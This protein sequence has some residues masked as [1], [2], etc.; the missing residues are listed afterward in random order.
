[1]RHFTFLNFHTHERAVVGLGYN[2][3]ASDRRRGGMWTATYRVVSTE[4]PSHDPRCRGEARVNDEV[5]GEGEGSSKRSAE[6]EAA[7]DAL[8]K[9]DSGG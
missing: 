8:E 6:R 5:R 2:P 1:M 7:R 9:E 3:E 4:G